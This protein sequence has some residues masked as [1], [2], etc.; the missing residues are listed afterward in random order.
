M[1][2]ILFEVGGVTVH[3]YGALGAVGFLTLAGIALA[4]AKKLGIEPEHLADL[5]FVTA[6]LSL[7]GARLL[8]VWQNPQVVETWFDIVNY[9][10]GGLV[11]YGALLTGV[12]LGTALMWWRGMPILATWDAFATAFPIGHGIT[13]IGCFFAGCCWGLPSASP[14]AVT[15][16]HDL[17]IGP[18]DVAVHPVQLYEAAALFVVGAIVNLAYA[19]RTFDGQILGLY[20]FS[21]GLVRMVTELYRGDATRG[22]FLPDVLGETLSYSQGVSIGVIATGLVVWAVGSR[23]SRDRPDRAEASS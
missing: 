4:R 10:K 5:I 8:F 16:T 3:T 19:R 11:F 6:L 9:R 14:W 22:F 20:L 21:Y 23:I 17:A 7:L 15:Y 1:H 13:R 12:P 18:H 2:P